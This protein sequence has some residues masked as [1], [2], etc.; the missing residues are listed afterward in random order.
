[1]M[2]LMFSLLVGL[3]IYNYFAGGFIE[4]LQW[5]LHLISAK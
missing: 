3:S 5:F 2:P 4:T 1:M